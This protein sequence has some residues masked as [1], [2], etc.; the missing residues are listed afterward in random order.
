[1]IC[2]YLYSIAIF[3][4][5][6]RNNSFLLFAAEFFLNLCICMNANVWIIGG[7]AENVIEYI[8]FIFSHILHRRAIKKLKFTRCEN[9]SNVCEY[10]KNAV[11]KYWFQ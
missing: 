2:K 4:Y 9:G 5:N 11:C 6:E 7:F 10:I 1:M 8:H 3:I